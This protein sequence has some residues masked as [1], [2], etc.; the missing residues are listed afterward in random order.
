MEDFLVLP[1]MNAARVIGWVKPEEIWQSNFWIWILQ[2]IKK[3]TPL[4]PFFA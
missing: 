1:V 4:R 2:V 3:W